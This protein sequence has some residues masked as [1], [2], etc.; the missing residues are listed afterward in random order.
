MLRLL[1]DEFVCSSSALQ[2]MLFVAKLCVL[3]PAAAAAALRNGRT[4]GFD[5]WDIVVCEQPCKE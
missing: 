4:P 2:Y 1:N 5:R 3:L